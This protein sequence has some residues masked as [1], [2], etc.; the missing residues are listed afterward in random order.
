MYHFF[1][2]KLLIQLNFVMDSVNWLKYLKIME[3]LFKS[4]KFIFFTNW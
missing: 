2:I 3:L 4:L 1:F